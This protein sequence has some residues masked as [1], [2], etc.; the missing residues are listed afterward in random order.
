MAFPLYILG[1]HLSN[2]KQE[3]QLGLDNRDL[4]N[5][6]VWKEKAAETECRTVE[7]IAC[8]QVKFVDP[9]S[10]A[11]F[12]FTKLFCAASVQRFRREQV[13]NSKESFL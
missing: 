8:C 9:Y 5:G 3:W 11:A 13:V 4:R 2:K 10:S 12:Q 6:E 7:S 1:S